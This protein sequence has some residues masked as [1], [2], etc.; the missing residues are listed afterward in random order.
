MLRCYNAHVPRRTE[1]YQLALDFGRSTQTDDSYRRTADPLTTGIQEG[2]RFAREVQEATVVRTPSDAASYFLTHIFRAIDSLDQEELWILLL[3]TKNL[4]THEVMLYR[5]T[6]NS[7]HIRVAEVY[8][9]AIRFNAASILL[10]H[11]HPSGDPTPSTHDVQ[12][13]EILCKISLLLEIDLL[14][15]IVLANGAW[16][17]LKEHG[18]GFPSEPLPDLESLAPQ[19]N[20]TGRH[21]K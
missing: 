17:S 20:E 6:L 10:A 16:Y 2:A 12:L 8:K 11:N 9:E 13:T 3:N 14:D 5:G 21:S 19:A 18:M 1:Q 15:H 4:I 7:V